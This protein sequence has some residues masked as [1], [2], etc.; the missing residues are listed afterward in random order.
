MGVLRCIIFTGRLSV[1]PNYAHNANR[2]H[3]GAQNATGV[4]FVV[5]FSRLIKE[6]TMEKY[7]DDKSLNS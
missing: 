7:F 1:P 2:G 3:G 5:E 4:T 6:S